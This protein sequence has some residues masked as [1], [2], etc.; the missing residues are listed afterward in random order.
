[1]KITSIS[2]K[3][4]VIMIIKIGEEKVIAESDV[5]IFFKNNT[6]TLI[7]GNQTKFLYINPNEVKMVITKTKSLY[8]ECK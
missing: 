6:T 1:M 8:D 4:G 7:D 5:T 3:G 2:Y